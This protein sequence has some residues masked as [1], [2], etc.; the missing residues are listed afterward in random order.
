MRMPCRAFGCQCVTCPPDHRLLYFQIPYCVHVN[1]SAA[2]L[3]ISATLAHRV[4]TSK[5]ASS[6]SRL[7][8]RKDMNEQT[9][10]P[11]VLFLNESYQL[12][13]HPFHISVTQENIHRAVNL[14]SC[15]QQVSDKPNIPPIHI[16]L[17]NNQCAVTK[18]KEFGSKI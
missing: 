8:G 3:G 18:N 1:I 14:V 9:E 7:H 11:I 13:T 10:R 6:G 15:D 17:I 12:R 2:S 16:T 4:P 5:P